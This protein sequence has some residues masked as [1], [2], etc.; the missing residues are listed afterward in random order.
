LS[1]YREEIDYVLNNLDFLS[2]LYA[3]NGDGPSLRERYKPC[4]IVIISVESK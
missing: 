1:G 2:R 3:S 4:G